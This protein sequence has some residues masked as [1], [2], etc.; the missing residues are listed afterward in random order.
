[1]IQKLQSKNN[2]GAGFSF[3]VNCVSYLSEGQ[4]QT[5]NVVRQSEG[6]NSLVF[7]AVA[8]GP[9]RVRVQVKV[10]RLAGQK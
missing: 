10:P 9:D 8:S 3:I 4:Q 1:M 2:I 6:K 5:G 7:A